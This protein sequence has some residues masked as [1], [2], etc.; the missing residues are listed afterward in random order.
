MAV[1]T[2]GNWSFKDPEF[3]D[4]RTGAHVSDGDTIEGG[5]FS[6]HTPGT[7][8]MKG[9]KNLTIRGGNFV[10]VKRQPTWMVEGGNWHQVERCSHAHPKWVKHGLP[11]CADDCVHRSVTKE[12]A[13]VPVDEFREAKAELSAQ[14]VRVEEAPDSDGV[15]EQVFKKLVYTYEDKGI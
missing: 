10:N 5:N 3:E 15:R 7:E 14:E 2:R 6:Q 8:I 4:D 12:W 1:I 11:A 9:Y 13:E